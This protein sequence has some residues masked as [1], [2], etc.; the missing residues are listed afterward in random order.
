M[1]H[2]HQR[3]AGQVW[4]ESLEARRLLSFSWSSEEVYLVELVNRA[5]MDPSAEAA[6][7]GV[8]LTAD[9][10]P[11]ELSRLKPS[12]PL[13]LEP[14][15]TLAA[16]QHSFD[17]WQ[18]DF[19]AHENPDGHRAQDRADANGYD[20]SAGENIAAGYDDVD[21]AHVAWLE[22][23]GHR[24]NVLSL[25][26]SFSTNFHYDE[27]G[28]GFHFPGFGSS[29]YHSY[30]TQVFGHSGRPPRTY[31]L[32]VVFDDTDRDEFYSIGEGRADVRV[33]LTRA[34]D[35]VLVGSY[36]TNSAGNYQIVAPGG[37][38][39]LT[40]VDLTTGLGR[41]TSVT[42]ETNTN[43][44]V[45]ATGDELTETLAP[46][47]NFAGSNAAIT[48]S[49][50]ADGRVAITT[51]NTSGRPIAFLEGADAWTVADLQTLTG[52][53]DVTGQIQTFTDPRDGLTYAAASSG[54][55]L[56]LFRRDAD[57]LWTLR[58]LNEELEDAGT[59]VG[60]ITVFVS[61]GNKV[62]I[63]GLDDRN[64]LH[65]FHQTGTVDDGQ[66]VWTSRNLSNVDLRLEGKATPRFVGPLI[67]FVTSWNA[68]NIAGLDQDGNIQAVWFHTSIPR[69]TVSNLSESTGAPPLTGGLTAYLTSWNAINLV[70]T[71]AGGNV[72]ATWWVPS[73]GDSWVT[74]NLTDLFGGPELRALSLTS[75]VTPWGAT[76][77]AGIDAEGNLSV[78]WWAPS[79]DT[80]TVSTLSDL[81]P[82]PVLPVGRLS[83]LT[84]RATGAINIFGAGDEGEVVRYWWT[85]GG[86]W[87]V[88]NLTAET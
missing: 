19:F 71:D 55:G 16:R 59:P 70:G 28:V 73:F 37:E 69:W 84:V 32:G 14:S 47:D 20:G 8:D 40:F 83:G 10:S 39:H 54:E 61:R 80:W 24:K 21:E 9:L 3:K 64:Q 56:L 85:P 23:V 48:G 26:E 88:Q 36:T 29:T 12:E 27:I 49:A 2:T 72:S 58:N 68:L 62:H 57:G 34:S 67:S 31:V 75:F 41:R 50:R 4:M 53:P 18:R 82:D 45:D 46:G 38:Y 76:N 13:A 52:S 87:A 78:Y 60:E 51:L 77:I 17:M 43:V 44:K 22:S 11:G 79:T 30:Y 74:S 33:D 66:A 63:A 65:L 5:R 42:V 81:V 25:W 86:E 15:L 1:S 6:R 35:G 7:T